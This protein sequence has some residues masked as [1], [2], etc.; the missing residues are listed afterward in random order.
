MSALSPLSG[1]KRKSHLTAVRSAFGTKRTSRD[2]RSMVANGGKADV[3][4]TAH[5]GR[6]WWSRDVARWL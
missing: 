1:A 4:L 2:V 3:T 6:K 5:F